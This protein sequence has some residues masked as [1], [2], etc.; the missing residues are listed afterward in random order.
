MGLNLSQLLGSFAA[1][2]VL[3]ATLLAPRTLF[4]NDEGTEN[5]GLIFDGRRDANGVPK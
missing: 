4:Y 5:G 3:G 2:L 1:T